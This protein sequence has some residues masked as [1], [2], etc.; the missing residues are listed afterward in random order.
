VPS[1]SRIGFLTIRA[2]WDGP[3]GRS[4]LHAARDIGVTDPVQA[5]EY[6]RVIDAMH[7]DNVDAVIVGDA[8]EGVAA[9]LQSSPIRRSSV[10]PPVPK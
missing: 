10:V 9:P 8:S 6:R 1:A 7:A 3:Q 4:L 5:P 2:S